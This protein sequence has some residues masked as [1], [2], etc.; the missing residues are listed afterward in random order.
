MEG[1]ILPREPDR[2]EDTVDLGPAEP[3]ARRAWT[4]P[5]MTEI[6]LTSTEA[7]SIKPGDGLTNLS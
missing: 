5:E 4:K 7:I 1:S 3:A 2:R 6:S